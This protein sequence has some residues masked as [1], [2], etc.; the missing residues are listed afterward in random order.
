M[1]EPTPVT[2]VAKNALAYPD[3]R[4]FV[5]Q[6]L[7]VTL[8]VSIQSVIVGWQVYDITHRAFSLGLVGLMQFTPNIL[9]ALW[10]GHLA[11]RFDRRIIIRI[12][13]LLEM[14]C[15]AGLIA[16]TLNGNRDVNL[17]Y[18]V[19]LVFGAA[20]ALMTPATQSII[21]RLVH[22][23]ALGSAIALGSSLFMVGTIAGPALGGLIYGFGPAYAFGLS[24]CFF[25]LSFIA[26]LFIRIKLRPETPVSADTK[27]LL[28]GVRFIRAHPTILGA[29]SLD[30]FAVLLGGATALLPI[31]A[32]DI[33]KIGPQGLGILRAAPAVGAFFTSLFLAKRSLGGNSG[34]K[35]F[36]AVAIFG[37]ATIVFGLSKNFPLSLVALITLGAADVVSVYMRS[38]LI[39]RS[40]PDEMRGRVASVNWVFIGASNEL[41]EMESGFTAAL[42]GSAVAAAV[43]GGI[44]TLMIV[45]IWAGLFP[46]LRKVN[47][48]EEIEPG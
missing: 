39:Q 26:T 37:L 3:Y 24:C 2:P 11:D 34:R 40:T 48:L 38:N 6:R 7:A 32:R 42:F 27:G 23:E 43:A 12:A 21:P 22:R 36:I 20:R 18:A 29:I 9:L 31:Y 19:L 25:V 46:A 41:G 44:G 8:G 45:G 5:C 4:A 17:I 1:T 28:A 16:L 14:L 33:L 35:M 13:L 15:S 47:R 30:L 10:T